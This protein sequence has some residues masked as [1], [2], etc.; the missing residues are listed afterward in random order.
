M[1]RKRD[2]VRGGGAETAGCDWSIVA[3][4]KPLA[5]Y[6]KTPEGQPFAGFW[7]AAEIRQAD[8]CAVNNP[9]GL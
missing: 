4:G 3:A 6:L 8:Q 9:M 2:D 1:Y 7:S 5:D